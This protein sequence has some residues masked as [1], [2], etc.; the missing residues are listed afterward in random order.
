MPGEEG[1][2]AAVEEAEDV[3][4]H[5]E[6]NQVRI[7]GASR[8]AVGEG[9]VEFTGNASSVATMELFLSKLGQHPCFHNV[10]RTKQE[11]LKA[12]AGKE[13]WWRFTVDFNVSCPQKAADDLKKER[14]GEADTPVTEEGKEGKEEGAGKDDKA[15][16]ATPAGTGKGKGD[17]RGKPGDAGAPGAKPGEAGE[18]AGAPD[19]T[20]DSS[21]EGKPGVAAPPGSEPPPGKA[22][23]EKAPLRKV[24]P[25]GA[26][27]APAG[28]VDRS[29]P[30]RPVPR[31]VMKPQA[32]PK[33]PRHRIG[34]PTG[35]E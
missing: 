10:Q 17:V 15:A 35:R 1:V 25:G 13:G 7:D 12:T 34:E 22:G 19:K 28:K 26:L 14:A 21:P 3:V 24:G 16:P 32:M 20:G 11:M 4:H 2:P 23:R 33:M 8:T 6:F 5:L 31:D 18:K 27:S 9:A 29:V 30:I